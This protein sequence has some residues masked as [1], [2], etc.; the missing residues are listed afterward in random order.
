MDLNSIPPSAWPDDPARVE[1][2][3][4]PTPSPACTRDVINVLGG[5]CQFDINGFTASTWV[6]RLD[7][8]D[9]FND[10]SL[11]M[12]H[13]IVRFI[14][15]NNCVALRRCRDHLVNTIEELT[16]EV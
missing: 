12:K 9:F 2:P 5:T 6:N 16:E 3:A 7:D 15:G 1:A 4:E 13:E 10:L 8:A 11:E 14:A